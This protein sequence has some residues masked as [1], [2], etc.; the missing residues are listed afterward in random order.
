[1]ALA[2]F[3][4]K[5][6]LSAQSVLRNFDLASF[7]RALEEQLVQVHFG[8][9]AVS[10]EGRRTLDLLVDLLSR[11][12]PRLQFT[13]TSELGGISSELADR[14]RRVSQSIEIDQDSSP[15]L[16]IVLGRTF[17]E[18]PEHTFY[19]GS[20]GWVCLCSIE[21]PR[22]CGDSGNPF[23]AGMAAC[24]A[25]AWT[26]RETFQ[27]Q[28]N[29]GRSFGKDLALSLVDLS[30]NARVANPPLRPVDIGVAHLVGAG[31]I[32]QATAWGLA[33]CSGLAG[34]VY[35][36]DGECLELSNLQRYVYTMDADVGKS[37]PDLA[38]RLL[39]PSSAL[40]VIP[41]RQHWESFVAGHEGPIDRV[42]LALDSA[43]ARI[44]VQGS[45]PRWV[46]NAWTQP[47]N[48]GVSRHRSFLD[49]ACVACLYMPALRRKSRDRL[50]A[51]SLGFTSE[52]ELR[53][54]RALLHTGRAIGREFLER[55]ALRAGIPV[56]G[57]LQFASEPLSAFYANG[58]CG[59]LLLSFS[60]GDRAIQVQV[61]MAFQSAAAGLLLA[62]EL[63]ADAG[64]LRQASLPT[65][66]E[67][68]LLRDFTRA[69]AHPHSPAQKHASGRCIC[70]D[71]VYRSFY[72]RSNHS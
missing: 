68:D 16:S 43:E 61:P 28:L 27:T 20:D 69:A 67:L 52:L 15:T 62:A 35:V 8:D 47:E 72:A 31:A 60:S 19:V 70:Q 26:F 14:A 42:L 13:S 51:D 46:A 64:Q 54:V 29:G 37:K 12:Y 38:A 36:I 30:S 53:E 6:A 49:D 2:S 7:R 56:K 25:A 10:L 3:F 55:I 39:D 65:R 34:V 32:G 63:V 44:H 11:L 21:S 40:K 45:L 17:T 9:D 48:I 33:G 59:G 57:L 18:T 71:T 66:S 50:I 22:S 58:I 1:M 5:A 4:D 23:G 41:I 24:L